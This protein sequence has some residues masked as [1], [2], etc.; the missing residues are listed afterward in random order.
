MSTVLR[1]LAYALRQMSLSRGFAATTIL[2]IALAIGANT[3][4][5]SVVYGVLL[6]SLPFSDPSR[7]VCVRE[8]SP[9]VPDSSEATYPDYLAWKVQQTSFDDLAAYS[10]LNPTTVTLRLPGRSEQVDRVLVSGNFFSLLGVK[11]AVGRDLDQADDKLNGVQVAMLSFTAWQRYFNSDPNIAG[12]R[13]ALDGSTFTIVGVLPVASYPVQGDVWLPL[14]QL[15]KQIRDSR[16]WHSVK[17]VGRLRQGVTMAQA[18]SEMTTI[19]A[20]LAA[21]FPDSNHGVHVDLLPLRD[22]LVGNIRPAIQCVMGSVVL[23]LFIAC[24]NVA[25][26]FLVRASARRGDMAIRCV[27]G[28]SRS[29]LLVQNSALAFAICVPGCLLGSLLAWVLLPALRSLLSHLPALNASLVDSVRINM[30]V[31]A[32]SLALCAATALLFGILPV[33]KAC[34]GFQTALRSAG[35]GKTNRLASTR[36]LLLSLE[37]ALALVAVFAG[38]LLTRSYAKLMGVNSGYRTDHL[39]SFEISLPGPKYQESSLPTDHFYEQ[40]IDQISHSP[41]VT[42]VA[43][44]NQTPLLPSMFMTRFLIEGKPPAGAGVFPVAQIRIVNPAFFATAGLRIEEGRRFTETE[45]TNRANVLM[46]NRRFAEEF[47]GR[48]TAVGSQ[49]ILGV[50]SPQPNHIPIIG[51]VSSAHDVGIQADAPPE[52]FVPGYSM[53]SIVLVR[54][55][56]DPHPLIPVVRSTVTHLEPGQPVYNVRTIDETV[57]ESVAL[58]R[59][60]AQ[61]VG[62]FALIAVVLAAVG[63]YGVLSYLILLRRDEIGIRIALG[64]QRINVLSLV[65]MGASRAAVAGVIAGLI[66][67]ILCGRAAAGLL[68]SVAPVD[69]PSLGM[70]LAILLAILAIGSAAPTVRVLN[71]DPA[72][73]L[74]SE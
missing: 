36:S 35:R 72:V 38:I 65:L 4:I 15:N 64:A 51:V 74:K 67:V 26:L 16:V 28:A 20:T 19:A 22:Q 13:I 7:L 12:S 40:L 3:A 49:I 2:T 8:I 41:G 18:N 9:R 27:L 39:L 6:E 11:P 71:T 42:S 68:F 34:F 25:N 46:V 32:F 48:R 10:S 59:L 1:D 61:L 58:E 53:D 30:S 44:T 21:Q 63:I 52:M 57:S 62:A 54:T 29:R 33:F 66:A 73:V 43:T 31:F 47:L 56:G 37:V 45:L 60:T 17:V 55:M 14:S 69:V 5:F 23:V 70:T 24:A 50:L